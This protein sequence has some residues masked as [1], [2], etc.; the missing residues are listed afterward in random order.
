MHREM[1]GLSKSILGRHNSM[2]RIL[3]K[4]IKEGQYGWSMKSKGRG[5]QDVD[6]VSKSQ[7][8][9][10]FWEFWILSLRQWEVIEGF[11]LE[12]DMTTF[13]LPINFLEES[14]HDHS[15]LVMCLLER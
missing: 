2:D 14:G 4:K 12:R 13:M 3:L 10:S 7:F 11:E 5:E 9:G 1:V 6:G 8:K 15:Y